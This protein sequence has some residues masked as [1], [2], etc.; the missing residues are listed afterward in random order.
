[1]SESKCQWVVNN[2]G[3]KKYF[4]SFEAAVDYVQN[5]TEAVSISRVYGTEKRTE[6]EYLNGLS[7]SD[8]ALWLCKWKYPGFNAE[9]DID[10]ARYRATLE[11]LNSTHE[12]NS[13]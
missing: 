8:F 11:M 3:E 1:M 2:Y 12:R 13:G 5:D 6:R 4:D 7:D 10:A 9:V